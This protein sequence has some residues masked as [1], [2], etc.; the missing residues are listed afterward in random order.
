MMC[1]G[2]IFEFSSF[3]TRLRQRCVLAPSLQI[4]YAISIKSNVVDQ[5]HFIASVGSIKFTN[6]V[7]ADCVV[8]LAESLEV[9]VTA[10]KVLQEDMKTIGLKC[11]ITK[12]KV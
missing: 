10:L 1:D 7:F 5:S 3:K 9:L 11:F 4:L 12:T 2:E 8:N 6:L